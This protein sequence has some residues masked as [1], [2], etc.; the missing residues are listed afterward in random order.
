MRETVREPQSIGV[1]IRHAGT[2][3]EL[4]IVSR[5]LGRAPPGLLALGRPARRARDR[6]RP[7][8]VAPGAGLRPAGRGAAATLGP[9]TSRR[10]PRRG[11][12]RAQR[13]AQGP[14]GVPDPR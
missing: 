8:P 2:Y 12:T 1:F 5:S 7:R 9:S 6:L 11:R 4:R 10:V 3:A 13:L 14:R